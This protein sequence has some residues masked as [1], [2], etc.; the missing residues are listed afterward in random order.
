MDGRSCGLKE[1]VRLGEAIWL[2]SVMLE[3]AGEVAFMALRSCR[4]GSPATLKASYR[5]L[6]YRVQALDTSIIC[7]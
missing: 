1:E 3:A 7:W 4:K 2:R 5:G 6:G